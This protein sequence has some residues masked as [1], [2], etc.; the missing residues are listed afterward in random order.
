MLVT[1]PNLQQKFLE[2][3]QYKPAKEFNF[4]LSGVNTM[5]AFLSADKLYHSWIS[6]LDLNFNPF[7]TYE[8]NAYIHC[9]NIS[10][11]GNYIAWLTAHSSNSDNHSIFF[12]DVNAQNLLWKISA[13]INI[14]FSKGVF[15][16]SDESVI[17]CCY[18]NTKV[19]YDFNGKILK[20]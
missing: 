14:K 18:K 6:V 5:V 16:F 1:V 9:C 13:P 15:I 19:R 4:I 12:Y 2:R 7:F 8:T 10:T 17:E 11:D 20:T 3:C